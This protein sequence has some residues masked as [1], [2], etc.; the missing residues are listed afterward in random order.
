VLRTL[1]LLLTLA[2]TSA[3]ATSVELPYQGRLSGADG[4]P[5]TGEHT[6]TVRLYDG[7]DSIVFTE[8]FIDI[9]ID[10]GYFSIRLGADPTNFDLQHTVVGTAVSVGIEVDTDGELLPRSPLGTVPFATTALEADHALTADD[11]ATVAGLSPSQF[12]A[13]GTF[14]ITYANCAWTACVDG[15]SAVSTCPA[16]KV[17]RGMD[18]ATHDS[19]KPVGCSLTNHEDEYRS[20][21]CEA[22][23]TLTPAD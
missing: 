4:N 10:N 2:P 19:Q 21:C 18:V 6:V 17:M 1:V 9:V 20:Y 11:S 15:G 12:A 7:S 13:P 16:N 22:Q 5:F 14:T 3:F 8:P 23:V